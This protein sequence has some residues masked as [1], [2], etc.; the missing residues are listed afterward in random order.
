MSSI[1][2]IWALQ[3]SIGSMHV[4]VMG[5]NAGIILFYLLY[6]RDCFFNIFANVK[7]SALS[8]SSRFCRNAFLLYLRSLYNSKLLQSLLALHMQI[9]NPPHPYDFIDL[10]SIP[11]LFF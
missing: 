11:T 1:S 5:I 3:K 2:D 10:Y 9:S 7:S 6:R 4:Y 8:P